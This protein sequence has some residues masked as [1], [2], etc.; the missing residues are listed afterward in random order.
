MDELLPQHI[1]HS[2]CFW[3]RVRLAGH[4]PR[5]PKVGEEIVRSLGSDSR[6]FR[7]DHPDHP[8]MEWLESVG[9]YSTYIYPINV[10][11]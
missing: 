6:A 11:R 9:V 4:K 1:G 5:C 3:R 8:C 10:Y 2:E 7:S